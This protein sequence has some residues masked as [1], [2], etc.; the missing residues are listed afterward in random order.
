MITVKDSFARITNSSGGSS[1]LFAFTNKKPKEAKATN[2]EQVYKLE[3][4][5]V[6]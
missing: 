6:F 3:F 5:R 1:G 4:T 2:A